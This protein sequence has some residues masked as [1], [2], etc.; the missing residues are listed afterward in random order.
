MIATSTQLTESLLVTHKLGNFFGVSRKVFEQVWNSLTHPEGNCVAYISMEIGADPDVYSPIADLLKVSP[1]AGQISEQHRFF[2]SKFREGPQKIPNYSGG[3]G[4]L[5]GD[6]LKSFADCHLPVIAVSLLYRKGYFAQVVDSNLG[7]ISQVVDWHPEEVPGLYLLKDP[8]KPERPL[9]IEIPFFTRNQKEHIVPAQI[10]MK[11]EVSHNL[12]YF[13]PELLLDF[14]LPE[15]PAFIKSAVS[16]LYNAESSMIKAIQRRMLGAGILP[17]LRALG[18]SPKTFHLNEQHGVVLAT[19]LIAEQLHNNYI[20]QTTGK[21]YKDQ[22]LTAANDVAKMLVYT[23]HTPVKAGHD[24]FSKLL[25]SEICSSACKDVLDILAQDDEH[26]EE[27]NFTNMA[28]RVNRS[29]NSVSRLHRDVTHKQFP[30]FAH[31]ISAIT[32]GVHHLTWISENR[33]SVFDTF[34]ELENWRSNPGVFRNAA[35]LKNNATF[36]SDLYN[37]WKKD[38]AI[39]IQYINTMLKKHRLQMAET[40][41]DPPNFLSTISDSATELQPDVFTVG[42]ARRFSTYKR[43]DLIFHDLDMLCRII[44]D[45]GYPINLVFAGKAHPA[46]EPG[47]NVLK[48][49]LSL[50]QKLHE[51]SNGL[52]NL[53]FIPGYDMEVAKMLVSGVHAWLNCPK[54]PLEASGTSGMKAA[55]NGVPNISIMDGWWVEGYHNGSTGWKFGH[56]GPIESSSLNE[57]REELLYFEDSSSFYTLLPNVLTE[58]YS[59][60]L[61]NDFI[62]KSIMNLSL[63]VPIFNTHR[64]AAEYLQRYDLVLQEHQMAEMAGYAKLYSSDI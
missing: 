20:E 61:S 33:S 17:A 35:R 37:A 21:S 4:I 48:Y 60:E 5:A 27:Y 49:L 11:M 3:L 25:Y 8:E 30:D 2:D 43:A 50:Q 64:M 18:I 10:W 53:I 51:K 41:I 36:R 59:A 55:M 16:Q 62:D 13:I 32:N 7:Q 6:T 44:V 40:W 22:I 14:D 54:R 9:I 19:Q 47:K 46:D 29:A 15:T 38:S 31:K 1:L 63:N 12:D 52:A 58:F 45:C 39:L 56:E 24:R 34:P 26:P 42:F 23:I 57:S 28:M